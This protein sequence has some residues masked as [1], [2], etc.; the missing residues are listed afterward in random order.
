MAFRL[1]RIC[2]EEVYFDKRLSELKSEFLLPRNYHSKV[3]D[4]KFNGVRNLPWEKYKEKRKNALKTKL[5]V[6]D[7]DD[8][9]K[10]QIMVQID[11]YPGVPKLN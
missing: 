3:I 6:D 2:S 4:S 10:K 11:F 7:H 1:L 8:D 9:K 5:I